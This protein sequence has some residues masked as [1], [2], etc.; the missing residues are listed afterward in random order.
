MALYVNPK[1][2]DRDY[3]LFRIGGPGLANCMFVA[4][5]AA[6][7]ARKLGA[8]MLRPTWERF[9][10]GQWIR[11]ERDKRFYSGLFKGGVLGNGFNKLCLKLTQRHIL[12]EAA[13]SAKKG[14][15]EVR[16]LRNYFADLLHDADAVRQYFTDNIRPQAISKVPSG[17]QDAVGI[18]IR[19]GDFPAE[20]RTDI[21]WYVNVVKALIA[22][23]KYGYKQRFWLFSDGLDCELKPL[24]DIPNVE[25]VCFGNAL[26]DIVAI[27][28]CRLLIGSDSTFSGWGAFLGDIPCVFAHIHYG[29]IL[30]DC[31]KVLISNDE[32]EI[33]SWLSQKEIN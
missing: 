16:G 20:Y 13:D 31:N 7:L 26:A 11:R 5:R 2:S 25:R 24:L 29:R 21:N 30:E 3:G 23:E 9:G 8:V 22:H 15:I 1:L 17:K 28:R 4:A 32:K 14:V 12:E 19:L 27:S 33:A 10:V 18:H 6:I